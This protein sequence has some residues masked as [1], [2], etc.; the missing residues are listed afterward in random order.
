MTN[1]TGPATL[2]PRIR[3]DGCPCGGRTMKNRELIRRIE[4]GT[5]TPG[6]RRE[7]VRRVEGR[8]NPDPCCHGH[9]DCA[10]VERGPCASEVHASLMG[11]DEWKGVQ[12]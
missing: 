4:A 3:G 1:G 7:Y 9:F 8:H 12:D 11:E 10:L 5:A 2:E 6:Q